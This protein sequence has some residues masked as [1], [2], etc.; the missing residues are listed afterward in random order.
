MLQINMADVVAVMHS[1]VPYLSVAGV[2]LLLAL[3]ITIAVNRKTVGDLKTRKII[4]SE[5][6]IVA[7]I[8]LVIAI[9]MMLEG[10]MATLLNNATAS[11]HELT[12]QTIAE[13]T[14]LSEEAQGEGITM[15]QNQDSNLPLKTKKINVFGWASTN[16][17]YGGSGSGSISDQYP[18][19]SLLEGLHSAGLET[20]KQV[21]KFYKDYK[22]ARPEVGMF[23]QD[24]SLPEPP[25]SQY[26]QSLMQN[27][28]SFSDQAIVVLART[29]GEGAD[30]PTNVKGEDMKHKGR[31]INFTDNTK[32]YE[33]FK[34]GDHI[35]QLDQ[36]ERDMID[37]VTKNF[38]LVTLIYNGANAFQMDFLDSYPQIKSVL[39]CPPAG[40]SGFKAL[41]RVLTGKINPSGRTSDT[42]L[43]DLTKS[44]SYN[45]FGFFE[46]R[47]TSEFNQNIVDFRGKKKEVKPHFV[48][49]TEGIYVGYRF[50]ETAA[51][52]GLINYD[53]MVKF[54]F[55]FGL[56]YTQF[57]QE[58]G[59]VQHEKGRISFDVT[60]T[61]TGSRAGKD[62][63]EI[64]YD[65]PY[66]DG[67]I[68]KASTNL[69][70]FDKTNLLK[71]GDSQKVHV[72]FND[73][74]MASYD[75]LR[76]KAYVLEAGDYAIRLQ[77]DAHTAIDS[78]TVK[79]ADTITYNRKGQTHNGDKI[80]ATN[81]FDDA[82]GE[83]IT[84]LSR[85]NHFANYSQATAAPANFT[86]S[87]TIKARFSNNGTYKP[88]DHDRN[89]D[90]MPKMGVDNDIRLASLRGKSYE[91]PLWEKLLDQ[92]TFSQM[93]DLIANSGYSTP[94]ISSIGKVKT[95]EADGPAA[96][97][98]NFTK[99]SS[100]GF[101]AST[102]FACSW[103][104]ALA[105]EYGKIIGKMAQEMHVNGWYAPAMNIHRSPFS[106]RSFEYFSEDP[107]IAGTMA[108]NEI[109]GA[110]SKGVYAFMKHFALNEQESNKSQML[111][112]WANEQSMREIFLK[113]FEMSVKQ[114]KAKAAMTS[115]NYVGP[116][117]A[118]ANPTLLT[119]LLRQEW[120][121]QGFTITDYFG[122]NGYMNADQIIRAGGD[123]M[124]ATTKITNHVTD[125]SATSVKAMRQ[126]CRNILFTSVNGWA[127]ANGEP[128]AELPSWKIAMR[129]VWV[130]TAVL[131]V[132]AEYMTIRRFIKR[133]RA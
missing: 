130:I 116:T 10:P 99:V 64:Y 69:V 4:H 51:K 50:Y 24:W 8:G 22:S 2:L 12:E 47:N 80:P 36:T 120:G 59:P 100:I 66:T 9:S 133:R 90:K 71:P 23:G 73:S 61:N 65:P 37:M 111:C 93:D 88:T 49:Y 114:G 1:L 53:S 3:I 124:L 25:A 107:L 72:A 97:I 109:S 81:I 48:N 103:N 119:T 39:W 86:M 11:K 96:L 87:D 105:K 70:A 110:Q 91:D 128:K 7:L 75:Y 35:L 118:G 34:F 26:P 123:A 43:K 89:S 15:L 38:Q 113:P 115:F 131:A 104:K 58:M 30:L 77:S 54:P 18:K 68:E 46:Y 126:A 74:D 129:V 92:L 40:Q 31:K 127:Y 85:A 20:N 29:G 122:G 121:F 106:G 94:E 125:K 67:G 108:A 62:V 28:K 132:L 117:Y 57:K 16:P 95:S 17:V 19:V 56:S 5:S 55:G 83:N 27:A 78:K 76:A 112:T 79:I 13:A 32:E 6:W 84:Y 44:N 33:D 45:N 102:S 14:K 82:E 21:T 98:N 52:E 60:V 42:F 101:P 41:G 63:V